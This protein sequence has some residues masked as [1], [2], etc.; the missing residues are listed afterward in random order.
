MM[1][2]E[3]RLRIDRPKN[4]G[5]LYQIKPIPYASHVKSEELAMKAFSATTALA[6]P[7]TSDYKSSDPEALILTMALTSGKL[8][9]DG[10]CAS[11]ITRGLR[12]WTELQ[13]I[14]SGHSYIQQ[15]WVI[16]MHPESL[17]LEVLVFFLQTATMPGID[18]AV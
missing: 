8:I 10:D 5:F 9:S 14:A 15:I 7:Y 2:A 6:F 1:G 18:Q 4:A 17:T 12:I 11:C 16:E 3:R 13:L